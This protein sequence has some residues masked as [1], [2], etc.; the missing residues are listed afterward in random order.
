MTGRRLLESAWSAAVVLFGV[1]VGLASAACD[2]SHSCIPDG[3]EEDHERYKLA[4]PPLGIELRA[5]EIDWLIGSSG[6]SHTLEID[7]RGDSPVVL[8]HAELTLKSHTYYD[9]TVGPPEVGP[10]RSRSIFMVWDLGGQ[11]LSEVFDRHPRFVLHFKVKG[12]SFVVEVPY[13]C[14]R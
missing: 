7:N 6:V 8:E 9:S 10:G 14:S 3:W 1:A 13:T 2:P 12:K 4:L 11:H 5:S